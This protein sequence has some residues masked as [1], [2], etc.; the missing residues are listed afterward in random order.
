MHISKNIICI[1]VYV[2]PYHVYKFTQPTT[3]ICLR[4]IKMHQKERKKYPN[5]HKHGHEI[6]KCYKDDSQEYIPE[7][8]CPSKLKWTLDSIWR[9][10]IPFRRALKLANSLCSLLD[11]V[12][13]LL[14]PSH[15]WKR[16]HDL[17]ITSKH[18]NGQLPS[19]VSQKLKSKS[20]GHKIPAQISPI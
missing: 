10:W 7:F 1:H 2:H 20:I 9:S 12:S 14:N 3:N 4:F 16:L 18:K 15:Q 8:V 19:M 13:P 6:I 17:V 5:N 11:A